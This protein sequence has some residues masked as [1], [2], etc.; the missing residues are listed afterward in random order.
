MKYFSAIA[1]SALVLSGFA[2]VCQGQ[3]FGHFTPARVIGDDSQLAGAYF[4]VQD[5]IVGAQAQIRYGA[6][7]E[8]GFGLQLGVRS[9][10][11]YVGRSGL[12][13]YAGDTQLLIGGDAKYMLRAADREIP[14]DLSLDFGVGFIDMERADDL[15]FSLSGQGGW[16]GEDP[17]MRGLEP[18]LGLAL[19]VERIT[20]DLWDGD[21][22]DTDTDLEVRLGTAYNVSRAVSIIAELQ[23]GR[24]TT[25]GVG[26]N[27]VF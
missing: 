1:L 9:V 7:D 13:E 17:D 8:L 27:L 22:T 23:A 5:D 19:V 10:D 4:T 15:L 6:S 2:G 3:A 24:E 14:L 25:F 21:K 12:R 20:F 18:Y 16:R 11:D 26:L